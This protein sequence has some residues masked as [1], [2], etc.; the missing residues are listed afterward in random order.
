M[1]DFEFVI[2]AIYFAFALVLAL[3]FSFPETL[4]GI[5]GMLALGRYVMWRVSD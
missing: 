2:M 1:S 4:Y 5:A 3:S